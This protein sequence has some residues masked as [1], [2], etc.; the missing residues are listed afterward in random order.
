MTRSHRYRSRQLRES[1]VC[2]PKSNIA[3][4]IVGSIAGG[5]VGWFMSMATADAAYAADDTRERWS[6]G[7]GFVLTGATTGLLAG[8]SVSK[9]DS[10]DSML[11]C[12]TAGEDDFEEEEIEVAE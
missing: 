5:L 11:S 8:Y 7:A 1:N 12:M 2:G 9:L 10:I 6:R 3:S 4:G